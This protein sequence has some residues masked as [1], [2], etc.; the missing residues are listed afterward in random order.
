MREVQ[1]LK[2]W[3]NLFFLIPF[4][5]AVSYKVWWYGIVIGTVFIISSIFHFYKEQKFVF[6]D[7]T[8]STLLMASNFILLFSGHWKT[9][10]SLIAV[11]CAVIALSFYFKQNKSNYNIYHG[12]WHIFSAAVSFFCVATFFSYMNLF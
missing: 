1:Q 6:V 3:S 7:V 10:Y 4:A 11:V 12:F 9:P 2:F 5:F 8:S